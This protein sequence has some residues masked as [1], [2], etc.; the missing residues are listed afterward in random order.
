[1]NK[2]TVIM[3]CFNH[4]RF[5]EASIESILSQSHSDLEL[6]IT[7]DHST[8]ESWSIMNS[9]A[10]RDPRILLVNH[11]ENRGLPASRNSGISLSTGD[12]IAFCDSDDVWE[13]NK[14]TTQLALL[15][16]EPHCDVVYSETRIINELGDLTGQLFSELHQLPE[17]RS[18][19]LF[20]EL[21][22]GNFIN[23][24][25]AT[26]RRSCLGSVPSFDEDL[27]VLEDWWYWIQLSRNHQFR[28]LDSPLARYRVHS[29]SS[30]VALRRRYPV[31]RIR[32]YHRLL[33]RYDDLSASA[34]ASIYA[35][36]GA[37]LCDLKRHMTG[38]KFLLR[39]AALSTSDPRAAKV[40]Y[41]A[42]ARFGASA[43]RME[44]HSYDDA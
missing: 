35:F 36:L 14:L 19:W 20:N 38:R 2:V 34:E 1:M 33:R 40:L 6:V 41:K 5:L 25:S 8:D 15:R 44:R 18:G 13:P 27:G 9:F 3:P 22:S 30:N 28:Y 26:I 16:D 24:Q 42:L 37:D 21:I 10:E 32:I 23:I 31:N 11:T 29:G 43:L 7:N 4:A 12:F 39:A 17:T